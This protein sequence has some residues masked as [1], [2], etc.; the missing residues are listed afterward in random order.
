MIHNATIRLGGDAQPAA[1]GS[2]D[3]KASVQDVIDR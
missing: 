1:G 3:P 2:L